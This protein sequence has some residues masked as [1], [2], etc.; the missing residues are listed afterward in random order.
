ML[1]YLVKAQY[2][3]V[4]AYLV[5]KRQWGAR[6]GTQKFCALIIKNKVMGFSAMHW[7]LMGMLTHVSYVTNLPHI[8]TSINIYVRYM[9]GLWHF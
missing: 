1:S 3:L 9:Q 8:P 6:V 5:M 2:F 7:D 4:A